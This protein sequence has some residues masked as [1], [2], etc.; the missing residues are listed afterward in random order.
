[1]RF[2]TGI[3]PATAAYATVPYP[4]GFTKDNCSIISLECKVSNNWRSGM[5]INDDLFKRLFVEL[6]ST[7]V[8]VYNNSTNL[9][10]VTFRVTLKKIPT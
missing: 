6:G 2:V 1:M 4:T 8:Q 7:N 3:F 9:Y 5:G 10:G